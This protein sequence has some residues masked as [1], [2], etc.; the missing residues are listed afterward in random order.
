MSKLVKSKLVFGCGYLGRRVARRW[1]DRGHRVFVVTRSPDRAKLLGEEGLDPILADVSRFDTLSDLPPAETVL[2]SIGFDRKAGVSRHDVQVGGLGAV[3][4]A[5]PHETGR[6]I[7]VSSTAVY[8]ETAGA[9][10]DEGTPCRPDRESGRILLAA[11]GLLRAHPLGRRSVVLRL[12]GLYGPGRIPR[13]Q[14]LISGRPLSVA[15]DAVANL[16]YVDDAAEIV[17]AA[18]AVA[19]PPATYIVSD[20]HPVSRREFYRYLAALLHLP[21]PPFVAPGPSQGE[22]SRGAGNK[23][24]SNARMLAELDVTLTCPSYR[25]GLAAITQVGLLP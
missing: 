7:Y 24:V 21:A 9:T 5:L 22:S 6:I 14:D 15:A 4:D 3:L 13:I 1:R 17:L 25:E 20:G 10:V 18:D 8:G 16:I 23:R 2:Y 12:A 19:K 11:E